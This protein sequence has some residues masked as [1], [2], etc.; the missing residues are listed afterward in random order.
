M[1]SSHSW[2]R[3]RLVSRNS[4]ELFI[5]VSWT[6]HQV[7]N[8]YYVRCL[9]NGLAKQNL[10]RIK[11]FNLRVWSWLRMN[12]GGVLNTCKS[13]EASL[14]KIEVACYRLIHL[15]WLSGGRVSNAWVTCLIEGDNSW[16]R[17]LIPHNMWL[18]HDRHIK[19]FALWDGPAS[20]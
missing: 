9:L 1:T 18:S 17:L 20:D 15:R 19:A 2:E 3:V 8:S 12:A 11:H 16:K 7:N 10:G 4:F 14:P 13:N 6:K 5:N